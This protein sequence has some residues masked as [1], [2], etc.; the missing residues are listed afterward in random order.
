MLQ[1]QP[2]NLAVKKKTKQNLKKFQTNPKIHQY[3]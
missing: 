2:F 1:V 3:G